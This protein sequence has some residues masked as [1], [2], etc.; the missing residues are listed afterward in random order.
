MNNIQYTIRNIPPA[1]DARLKAQ[2]KR[3]GISLNKLV[4]SKLG[5]AQTRKS[6]GSP[7]VYKDLSWMWKAL[8]LNETRLVEKAVKE[9]RQAD[10]ARAYA[11]YQSEKK[12]GAWKTD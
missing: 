2:A 7:K 5:A 4:L 8:P 9:A 3:Q 12:Q 11:Q 10:K 1:V 6:K